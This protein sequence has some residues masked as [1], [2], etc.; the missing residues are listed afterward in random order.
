MCLFFGY[1]YFLAQKKDSILCTP[2]KLFFEYRMLIFMGLM[3]FTFLLFLALPKHLAFDMDVLTATFAPMEGSFFD[4]F[5]WLIPTAWNMP[6]YYLIMFPLYKLNGTNVYWLAA[7][8]ILSFVVFVVF[9]GLVGKELKGKRFGWVCLFAAAFIGLAVSGDGFIIWRIRPYALFACLSAI[10]LYLFI[11]KTRRN[12]RKINI[13]F[14]VFLTLFV[15][16]HWFGIFLAAFYIVYDFVLAKFKFSKKLLVY[17]A[18]LCFF[19]F[20]FVSC[21]VWF[22]PSGYLSPPP[23]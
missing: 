3:L 16:T 18:P 12:E 22:F 15:M 23:H 4:M 5:K 13:L 17:I 11:L 14:S 20:W 21:L 7:P 19:L 9:C 10:V 2:G 8:S 1:I 6:L